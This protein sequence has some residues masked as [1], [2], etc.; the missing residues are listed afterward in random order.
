MSEVCLD[1][2]TSNVFIKTSELGNLMI[3]AAT[4]FGQQCSILSTVNS[5]MND[6]LKD[7]AE[8]AYKGVMNASRDVYNTAKN[9]TSSYNYLTQAGID[10][11]NSYIDGAY[12]TIFTNFLSMN[13]LMNT[14]TDFVVDSV[15][16]VATQACNTLNEA[17]TGIPSDV[18]LQNPG[19]AAAAALKKSGKPQEKIRELL[20][21][22][23]IKDL[24]K[25]FQDAKT[26]LN[27]I[28][29][30]PRLEKY[31]CTPV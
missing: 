31:K 10:E 8:D 23:G 2:A 30:A 19:L 9:I 6:D 17:V 16:T 26:A 3:Q 20:N 24:K 4:E 11:L 15:N 18:Q 1:L 28:P 29:R 21:N 14:M 22:R 5:F 7:T 12:N 13:A 25:Q 27:N